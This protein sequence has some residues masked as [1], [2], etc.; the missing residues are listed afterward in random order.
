V[1]YSPRFFTIYNYP[2]LGASFIDYLVKEMRVYYFVD[3]H[4]G[5]DDISKR[6]LK[7]SRLTELNNSFE[8]LGADLSHSEYRSALVATKAKLSK[9]RG[10]ICF[11]KRRTNPVLWAHYADKHRGIC[12]GFD[13]PESSLKKVTYVNSRLSWPSVMDEEFFMKLL[14]TKFNH[15]R[16]ESEYR[17]YTS[18]NDKI[19]DFYFLDFSENLKL[20][21]VIVGQE[22]NITRLELSQALGD[23]SASVNVSK[24][25]AAFKSFSIV[26]NKNAT[27]WV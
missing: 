5:L 22:A 11:S 21:E 8:F 13:I 24:A 18:L 4:Y 17:F 25:R 15:W 7:I 3:K 23:L 2:I 26:K 6:R 16:Y 12:L 14:F 1:T 20:M 19:G 9:T 27:L 10:L